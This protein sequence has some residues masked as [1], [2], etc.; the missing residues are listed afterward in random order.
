MKTSSAS[1]ALK[2]EGPA[3]DSHCMR[4]DDLASSLMALSA[5]LTALNRAVNRDDAQVELSINAVK[6]G[7]FGID[8]SLTQDILTQVTNLLSGQSVA[9]VCNA[10]TLVNCVIEILLL[11]KWLNGR[12]NATFTPNA[13]KTKVTVVVDNSATTINYFSYVG[14]HNTVCN[15]ACSRI[16][17]PLRSSGIEQL[18]IASRETVF[19]LKADEVDSFEAAQPRTVI[20]RNTMDVAVLIES[21]SSKDGNKWK[22][23]LGDKNSIYVSLEDTD[24]LKRIDAGL[25]RFGKGDLLRVDL[26]TT[27]SMLGS[28]IILE[29][30]VLKVYEHKAAPVQGSLF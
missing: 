28:K 10:Y 27:Q 14:F 20:S 9:V 4:I 8:L 17:A 19:T 16:A 29:Y 23:S 18:E 21:P 5:A 6:A 3:L 26:Q 15:D 2:F 12:Q 1:F 7:S 30:A 25:E 22:V 13:E 11:K 24:V